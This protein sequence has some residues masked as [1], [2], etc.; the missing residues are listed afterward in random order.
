LVQPHD[1][2]DGSVNVDSKRRLALAGNLD[3]SL[4]NQVRDAARRWKAS[5]REYFQRI[6]VRRATKAKCEPVISA[7]YLNKGLELES[8]FEAAMSLISVECESLDR[9]GKQAHP[10]FLIKVEQYPSIVVEVKSRANDTDLVAL[11]SATEVLAA[12]ELIGLKDNFCL[13]VCSPGIE[14]S[15]PSVIESCR[16]LCVIGISDLAEAILRLKEGTLTREG[17]YNWLT[18]PGVAVMEDLPHPS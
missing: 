3:P 11:N 14:P 9:A 8:A 6:H 18:T 17:F 1:L 15:V 4:P 12:S 13:T 7:L 16:R 2:M 10:D 5:E